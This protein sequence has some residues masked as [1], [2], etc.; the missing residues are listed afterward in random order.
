[1][2]ERD[3]A[4]RRSVRIYALLV[5]GLPAHFGVRY[6][7][8][9]I[10]TFQELLRATSSHGAPLD[11]ARFW[12]RTLADLG[13]TAAIL[14]F[15]RFTMPTVREPSHL[16]LLIHPWGFLI[17]ISTTRRWLARFKPYPK[18]LRKPLQF[19]WYEA[20]AYSSPQIQPE[21]L[22][23]GLL[24]ATKS[25]RQHVT[26]TAIRTTVAIIDRHTGH[27]RCS[28]P[29][30]PSDPVIHQV[31]QRAIARALEDAALRRQ[32]L[33]AL[34]LL[35]ALC[36]ERGT[37]VTECLNSLALDQHWLESQLQSA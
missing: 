14:Y 7:P 29:A 35:L 16:G 26:P 3:S 11:L 36:E 25:V 8:Q 13:V 2:G 18:S 21:H 6:G 15:E 31:S 17:R 20:R 37:V 5:R 1:M 10:Q 23:L 19:A 34:H 28:G 33:S 27:G 24:R 12:I 4:R 22:L 32:R 9:M 30:A